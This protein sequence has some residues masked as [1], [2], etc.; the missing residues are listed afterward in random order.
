MQICTLIFLDG[1][2]IKPFYQERLKRVSNFSH[3]P[4]HVYEEDDDDDHGEDGEDD[5]EDDDDDDDDDGEEDDDYPDD[6]V[7]LAH[8]DLLGPLHCGHHLLLVLKY[9]TFSFIFYVVQKR[10]DCHRRNG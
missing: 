1:R 2:G 6:G 5:G 4:A 10:D 3:S 7:E 9:Q 8:G